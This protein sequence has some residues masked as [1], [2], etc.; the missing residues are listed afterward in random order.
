MEIR[1]R[2]L[3]GRGRIKLTECSLPARTFPALS[4]AMELCLLRAR[5]F[6]RRSCPE[7]PVSCY[8]CKRGW[9]KS[10][11]DEQFA[12]PFWEP[13]VATMV[14]EQVFDSSPLDVSTSKLLESAQLIELEGL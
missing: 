3:S 6:P 4:Q 5:A 8:P 9:G 12:L 2:V 14:P 10:R 13:P 7:L 1:L 11:A